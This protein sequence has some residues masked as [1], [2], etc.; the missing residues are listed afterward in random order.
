MSPRRPFGLAWLLIAAV[1]AGGGI[2]AYMAATGEAPPVH[3]EPA[4]SANAPT[5]AAT[6]AVALLTERE[7][8]ERLNPPLRKASAM[9]TA[10]MRDGTTPTSEAAAALRAELREVQKVAYADMSPHIGQVMKGVSLL[11][12]GGAGI[13]FRD[14]DYAG[15]HLTTRCAGVS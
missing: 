2:V 11:P 3:A 1:L 14:W 10:Y 15:Q 9:Y 4:Q 8:C 5:S 13:S 12:A 6:S 7:T